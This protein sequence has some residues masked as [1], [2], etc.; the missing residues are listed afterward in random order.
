[1]GGFFGMFDQVINNKVLDKK[2]VLDLLKNVKYDYYY[3]DRCDVYMKRINSKNFVALNCNDSIY[4][5][6]S[7]EEL[8]IMYKFMFERF[9]SETDDYKISVLENELNVI[10]EYMYE[11]LEKES[12]F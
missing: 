8:V 5:G 3:H 7:F 10:K 12:G 9:V 11:C 2:N 4:E 6:K 1:M